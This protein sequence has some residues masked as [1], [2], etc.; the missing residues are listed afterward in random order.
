MPRI[1]RKIKWIDKLKRLTALYYY[2]KIW[3]LSKKIR[4]INKRA[5]EEKR[6]LNE[7]ITERL[8]K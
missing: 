1:V 4:P 6:F 3:K 2:T 5:K 8:I 7:I